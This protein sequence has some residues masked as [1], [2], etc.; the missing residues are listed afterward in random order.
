MSAG[1]ISSFRNIIRITAATKHH[2]SPIG[3]VIKN[4]YS[5]LETTADPGTDLTN[6]TGGFAKA[7][8]KQSQ[9]IDIPEK[10]ESYNFA[11]LLRNSKFIDVSFSPI[12]KPHLCLEKK[13]MLW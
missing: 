3:I 13:G 8:E 9:I 7:Y 2:N 10:E 11:S 4:L 1:R 12:S 5:T 6:K